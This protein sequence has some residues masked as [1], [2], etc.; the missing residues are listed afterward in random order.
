M[1]ERHGRNLEV[2]GTDADARL[3]QTFEF[4]GRS[5]IKRRNSPAAEESQ[6]L[7][8]AIVEGDLLVYVTCPIAE[9]QQATRLLF[10]TNDRKR[11]RFLSCPFYARGEFRTLRVEADSGSS[12]H[13]GR[14]KWNHTSDNRRWP[15]RLPY[16]GPWDRACFSRCAATPQAS[17]GRAVS[18]IATLFDSQPGY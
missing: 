13:H 5:Q 7:D 6:E 17:C 4:C 1:N 11:E 18:I 14:Y 10:N 12:R 3:P 2:H 9:C 16:R 8:E 15:R